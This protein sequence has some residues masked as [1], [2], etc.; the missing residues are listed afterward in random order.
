MEEDER[1]HTAIHEAGHAVIGR[2]LG[3]PCGRVTIESDEDSAGH[4]ISKD[5]LQVVAHWEKIGCDHRCMDT[6]LRARIL[7]FLA[8]RIAEEE[9]L[10]EYDDRGQINCTLDDLLPPDADVPHYADR[11]EAKC[12]QLS[13]GIAVRSSGLPTCS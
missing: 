12:A 2:V 10:G 8:G 1:R 5:C 9:C 3:L 7:T 13:G 4:A 11:L 6:V